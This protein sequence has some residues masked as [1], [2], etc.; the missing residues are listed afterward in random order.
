M[1]LAFTAILALAAASPAGIASDTWLLPGRLGPTGMPDGNTVIWQG[2]EGLVVLDPG[3]GG[4]HTG[5]VIE[6]LR[7]MDAVPRVVL[8][9]HW[10]LD[11]LG[12][13]LRLRDSF[14]GL[15]VRAA[16]G[17]A[18]AREGFLA[19]YAGFLEQQLAAESTP[20]QQARQFAAELA[21][22]ENAEGLAPDATIVEDGTPRLAGRPMEVHVETHA[23][24]DG[25]LWLYDPATR[26][27]AA[28]DL[29]V[30]PAPLFD[31]ACAERWQAAL[32]RIAATGFE[33][34]VPGHGRPMDRVEFT[35]WRRAFDRLLACA[36]GAGSD[37]SC[38]DGWFEDAGALADY[39]DADYA[40][41]LVTYYV[42]SQLR[43][44]AQ[45]RRRYC[46]G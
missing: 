31:T 42:Q 8:N 41:R 6:A 3:R 39:D 21:L 10:H 5:R 37:A 14:P 38:V 4:E 7:A 32:G 25:D 27:L 17:L 36:S 33:I 28:G 11:H 20:P 44:P 46:P 16:P 19:R 2:P 9:S 12:G 40:R 35:A 34:L 24:S 26:L 13:N 29:V 15:E 45:E 22:I 23:V 43:A 30:L 18:A 1:S